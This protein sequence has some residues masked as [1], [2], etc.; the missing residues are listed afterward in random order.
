MK[1][2]IADRGDAAYDS[3]VLLGADTFRIP[4]PGLNPA[5]K[6]DPHFLRFGQAERDSFHG[7]CDLVVTSTEKFDNNAGIDFHV[8]TTMRNDLYSYV[9]TAALKVGDDILEIHNGHFLLNGATYEDDLLPMEFGAQS[10]YKFELTNVEKRRD[11][12][13]ARRSYLLTLGETQ[14]EFKF[15]K[16]IMSFEIG[17]KVDFE[18]GVG[19]LGAFPTGDML[20]RHGEQM[21]NFNDFGMEWQVGHDDPILFADLRAPQLPYER[22]RMPAHTQSRRRLRATDTKLAEDARDACA[23]VAGND[24]QLCIDDVVMT[25]D[26]ELAKEW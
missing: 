26:L 25:G 7:E 16:H 21:N 14:I 15:Y 1:F 23:H 9:E 13:V 6:G 11:G 2:A 18:G 22:C 20:S 17:G 10:N 5:V 24:F 19:M 3:W 8:R 4:T 12:S